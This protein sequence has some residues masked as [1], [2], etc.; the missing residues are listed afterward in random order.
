MLSKRLVILLFSTL[1]MSSLLGCVHVGER[2]F[3]SV[4][5]MFE[6]SDNIS[7]QRIDVSF[8]NR[9]STVLY[10]PEGQWP[11]DDDPGFVSRQQYEVS[12]QGETFYPHDV[13]GH[14]YQQC[15]VEVQPGQT[16]SGYISYRSFG[17]PESVY[18]AN[19]L[20]IFHDGPWVYYI[21]R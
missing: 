20:L 6:Q 21:E 16:V 9:T 4:R 7:A 12:V 8:T 3:V 13:A 10:I 18:S 1:L 19:K 15:D 14:C 5:V 2:Q 11:F 17:L